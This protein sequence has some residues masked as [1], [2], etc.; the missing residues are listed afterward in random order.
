MRS[1]REASRRARA[2]R[3]EGCRVLLRL[4]D[5]ARRERLLMGLYGAAAPEER[6]GNVERVRGGPDALAQWRPGPSWSR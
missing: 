4:G 6:D 3:R 2:S 5:D 1:P